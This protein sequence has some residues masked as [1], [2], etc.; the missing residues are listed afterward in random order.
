MLPSL[1]ISHGAPT[2]ALDDSPVRS[3]LMNLPRHY[4]RPKAVL[5]VSAHWLTSASVVSSAI[6]PAT[7]HDFSG[8]P[9]ELYEMRYPASGAP[10]LALRIA[11]LLPQSS[12]DPQRGLD[13]G[14]WVPLSL[15]YPAADIP[16]LQ[17]SIQPQRSPE[18]HYM[19]GQA[20]AVLREE[21]VLLLAS[22]SLTHN[23]YALGHRDA[24]ALEM[25][26]AFADWM[27]Q[28]LDAH[29]IPALLDYRKQAPHA[30]FNHPTDEHLLPLF[31]ALGAG[32]GSARALHRSW[33]YGLLAMDCYSFGA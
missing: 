22:G 4:E 3:F 9:P 10:E 28:K 25:S 11:S 21:G 14:A 13:H 29:D 6:T 20:L 12:L 8:F 18:Y 32:G 24:E 33:Q 23:L 30:E 1:F 16:V 26:R 19:L 7:I 15:M 27:A 5:V 2:L 17:L 31:V